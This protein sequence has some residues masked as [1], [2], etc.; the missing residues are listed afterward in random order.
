MQ[1]EENK[2]AAAAASSDAAPGQRDGFEFTALG[3]VDA[4]PFP[5][6]KN[7]S[8]VQRFFRWGIKPNEDLFLRK[9][10][11]NQV[12]HA[13]GAD[14]F[15]KQLLNSDAARASMPMLSS[16]GEVT[17]VS[18]KQLNCNVINM[19]YFDFFEEMG[20][21]NSNTSNLQGCMEEYIHGIPCQDR[22]RQGLLFEEDENYEELQQDKYQNEFVFRL[23]QFLA[24]GGS[25]NQF[26]QSITE[27]MEATKLLYKDMIGVAKDETT[28][29][30]KPMSMVFKVNSVTT[31]NGANLPSTEEHPQNLLF[32]SVDPL[33]WH[34]N[35]FQNKWTKSW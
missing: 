33:K 5:S 16:I 32:V 9:F 24:L 18:F 2:Q 30:I 21:V 12:F 19:S 31:S 15:L 26:D 35:V 11:Y 29:E 6:L 10:R 20:I 23:M 14:D 8:Q 17:D 4:P 22:L 28:D 34:V 13:V 7:D 1:I 3:A 27:Y 25:M